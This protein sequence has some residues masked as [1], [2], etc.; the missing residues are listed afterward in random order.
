[1]IN[2]RRQISIYNFTALLILYVLISAIV[3]LNITNTIP[4]LLAYSILIFPIHLIFCI[5]F[6]IGSMSTSPNRAVVQ[7]SP[8]A[9]GRLFIAQSVLLLMTPI[10]CQNL[11]QGNSCPSLLESLIQ[12]RFT[13]P[14]NY[15]YLFGIVVVVY[16]LATIFFFNQT[17]ITKLRQPLKELN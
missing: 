14:Y 7:Y 5:V 11:K 17:E 2:D 15:N 1:M 4:N 8:K 3:H 16:L 6:V 9:I 12:S 13:I 10:D